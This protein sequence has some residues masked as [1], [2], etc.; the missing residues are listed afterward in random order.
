MTACL[1]ISEFEGYLQD[2]EALALR[3][4]VESHLPGCHKC[5]SILDRMAATARRVDGWLAGL[6]SPADGGEVDLAAGF[7]R[8]VARAE[9]PRFESS[10][11]VPWYV[12]LYRG[13]RDVIRPEKLAPLNVT[14]RPVQVRDIWGIQPQGSWSRYSS[15]GI[16]VGVFTMLMFGFSSPVV[17]QTIRR[18]LSLIDPTLKPFLPAQAKVARGGGGGGARE[19]LPVSRGQAPK[20]ALRQFV[21]PQITDHVPILAMDPTL[22]APPDTQLPQATLNNWGDPLAKLMNGSNGSGV[23]GGMGNGSGG[24]LGSG[25]G[26]GPGPGAGG[27]V[28][29]GVFRVGGGVSAPSVLVKVDPEY[30]EEARKAKFSGTVLLNVI[31][32]AEGRARD[33]RVARALG[34]GLD[35]K[36]V[37]AVLKWRFRPGMSNGKPVN[38]RAQIE[39]NFRLL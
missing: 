36:A 15:V 39:V 2:S 12:S 27:G 7:A 13:V 28:G 6:A 19:T 26:G 10:D 1:S 25:T 3:A 32:D 24:G 33:V 38:V 22:L 29:G 14:S 34:M 20:P 17:Q 23:G 37:E 16:H 9:E 31:V 35:E 11:E 8:V 18:N 5:R 4:N 30:S 21:P